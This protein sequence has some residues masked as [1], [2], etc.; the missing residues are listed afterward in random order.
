MEKKINDK[1]D[2]YSFQKEQGNYDLKVNINKKREHS[3]NQLLSLIPGNE[4]INKKRK[5]NK[6]KSINEKSSEREE[7][8]YFK[9]LYEKRKNLLTKSFTFK[10]SNSFIPTQNIPNKSN[11]INNKDNS[12]NKEIKTQYFLEEGK[13][14]EIHYALINAN[15]NKFVPNYEPW[16]KELLKLFLIIVIIY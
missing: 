5:K 16:D 2:F 4:F 12:I 11:I 10:E 7:K 8:D 13:N 6:N 9:K 3:V 1:F 15:N 14:Q